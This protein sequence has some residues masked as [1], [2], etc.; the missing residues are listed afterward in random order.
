MIIQQG[1]PVEMCIQIL[2]DFLHKTKGVRIQPKYPIEKKDVIAF[3]KMMQIV[4]PLY[5]H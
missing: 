4:L 3:E 2:A 1:I 5:G